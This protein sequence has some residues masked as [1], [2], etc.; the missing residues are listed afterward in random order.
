MKKY[1]QGGGGGGPNYNTLI[2]HSYSVCAF[3]N[4]FITF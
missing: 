3:S 4:K 2:D 1:N